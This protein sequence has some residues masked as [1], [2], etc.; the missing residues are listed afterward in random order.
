M[1]S[2]LTLGSERK[3]GSF[4]YSPESTWTVYRDVRAGK[5]KTF[6]AEWHYRTNNYIKRVKLRSENKHTKK[7]HQRINWYLSHTSCVGLGGS[8]GCAVRLETR[9]SRVQ[10]PPRLA[11][12]F[13]GDWSWKIFYGSF[14]PFHWF[15]K[16]SCQFLVK[17]YAQYWLTA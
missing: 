6:V 9:R 10:P 4:S 13:R 8:V 15:K 1:T 12:F 5:Y 17:E 2:I 16:G 7:K 14:S 3:L 11:T